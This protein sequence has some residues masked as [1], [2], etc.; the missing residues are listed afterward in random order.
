[1]PKKRSVQLHSYIDQGKPCWEKVIE[2]VA[3][4]PFCKKKL[5]TQI[6]EKYGVN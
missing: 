3:G 1:M 5:A 6:A 4:Y 2:F